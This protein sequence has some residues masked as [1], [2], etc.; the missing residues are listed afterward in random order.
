LHPRFFSPIIG[1]NPGEAAGNLDILLFSIFIDQP[2][3]QSKGIFLGS[4]EPLVGH[5]PREGRMEETDEGEEG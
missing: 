2:L 5:N 4:S 3:Y 1:L